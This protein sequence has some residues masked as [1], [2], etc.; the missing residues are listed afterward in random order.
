MEN[1]SFQFCFSKQNFF[2]VCISLARFS[3]VPIKIVNEM[4]TI[5]Q[6]FLKIQKIS[7]NLWALF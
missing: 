7:F 4:F 3:Q 5:F 6:Y 2:P 1:D